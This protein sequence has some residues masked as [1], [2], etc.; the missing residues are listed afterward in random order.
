MD[1]SQRGSFSVGYGS[2]AVISGVCLCGCLC[3]GHRDTLFHV[4]GFS[5]CQELMSEYPSN[6]A[7]TPH[8]PV[9]S[10]HCGGVLSVR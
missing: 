3:R 8:E 1:D 5:F 2:G 6:Q 7:S 10:L 4:M 9:T